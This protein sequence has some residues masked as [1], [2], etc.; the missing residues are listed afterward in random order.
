VLSRFSILLI[1]FC[2][3][4]RC[5]AQWS[6]AGYIGQAHTLDSSLAIRQPALETDI[7]F[8]SISYRSE[9]FQPPLYYGVRTGYNFAEHW[10]VE[11]ELT[12]LK[13]F[14]NVD[15]LSS[16]TGI[17]NAAQI[18]STLP[19]NTIVQRFSISHGVNLL[20]ANAI[21]RHELG[22]SVHGKLAPPYFVLRAGAGASIPHAE[23]TIQGRADEH[24]QIGNPAFQLAAS[25][26]VR[27]WHRLYWSGEYKFTRTHEHVDI[28]SGSAATL[29]ESH[30]IVT[31]P[32]IHF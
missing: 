30:H 4:L 11:A 5:T 18:N 19:V 28:N 8:S 22:R 27:A 14:A 12:H 10:G 16:V 17:L 24:Y 29:L 2:I 25:I 26:E 3:S 6:L 21:F 9:S 15:Q 1:V 13:V 20:L 23:S 7:R 32:V 31:G